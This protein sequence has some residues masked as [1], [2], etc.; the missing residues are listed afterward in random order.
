M[1]ARAKSIDMVRTIFTVHF[2]NHIFQK[3]LLSLNPKA[4]AIHFMERRRISASY[5]EWEMIAF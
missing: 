2:H 3:Q 1:K 4:I 5:A